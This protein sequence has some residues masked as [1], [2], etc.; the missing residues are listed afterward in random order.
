MDTQSVNPDVVSTPARNTK[1]S[2]QARKPSSGNPVPEEQVKDTV[3][4]SS[5]GKQ[6]LAGGVSEVERKSA[7]TGAP[8]NQRKLSVTD[9]NEVIVQIVDGETQ[10]VVRQIPD[11]DIVRLRDAMQESLENL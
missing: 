3:T 10:Q 5:A 7:D 11:E 4:V 9:D 2:Q 1:T 8:V 6:A